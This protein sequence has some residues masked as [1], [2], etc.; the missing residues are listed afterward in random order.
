MKYL[1]ESRME[2]NL[3]S[4]NLRRWHV[5]AQGIGPARMLMNAT[6]YGGGFMGSEGAAHPKV[7]QSKHSLA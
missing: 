2:L 1:K 7:P 4:A 5:L 6:N 3:N